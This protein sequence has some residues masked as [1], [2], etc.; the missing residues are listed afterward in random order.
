MTAGDRKKFLEIFESLGYNSVN[1]VGKAVYDKYKVI[2]NI[3]SVPTYLSQIIS[4]SRVMSETMANALIKLSKNHP[5]IIAICNKYRGPKSRHSGSI[6][7]EKG[8]DKALGEAYA[9]LQ[10]YMSDQG[11]KGKVEVVEE[12]QGF[13]DRLKKKK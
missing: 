13:V 4:G 8:C 2:G 6:L 3:K 12:F 5:D 11:L 10:Y 9:D 7:I 1:Q